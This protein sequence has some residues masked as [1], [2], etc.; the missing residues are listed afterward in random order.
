[1]GERLHA[2]VQESDIGSWRGRSFKRALCG[3][4]LFTDTDGEPRFR[5]RTCAKIDAAAVAKHE[6]AAMAAPNASKA[7]ASR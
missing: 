7:Q 4:W 1:M 5:C 6:A 3:V 2:V